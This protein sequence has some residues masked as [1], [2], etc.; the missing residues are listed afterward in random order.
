MPRSARALGCLREPASHFLVDVLQPAQLEV[1]HP[2]SARR[3]HHLFPA[4]GVVVTSE[5]DGED[6]FCIG[7]G[8]VPGG[9]R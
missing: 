5:G 2:M 8:Q 3:V 4:L 1:M 6:D 7:L 9:Q